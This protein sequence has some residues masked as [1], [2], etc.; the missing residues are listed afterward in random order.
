MEQLSHAVLHALSHSLE[1]ILLT[2]P[3]LFLVYLLMEFLESRMERWQHTIARLRGIGPAA[4]AAAGCIP[5]CGFSAAAASLYSRGFLT[6]GTLI[7]VFLSTSDEA[8]PVMLANLSGWQQIAALIGIK[9]VLAVAAGYLLDATVFRKETVTAVPAAHTHTH[10]KTDCCHTEKDPFRSPLGNLIWH[11]LLRTLQV[12]LFLIVTTFVIELAFHLIGEDRLHAL[13][14]NGSPLQPLLTALIGLI[15]GCAVSVLLTQLFIG[16]HIGFGA[17]VA[18][19]ATG[20]GVGYLVLFRE[21]GSLRKGLRI[22]GWTYCCA[23]AAGILLTVL[24]G[25]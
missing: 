15:P 24:T 13:L 17:A 6:G 23:A 12:T 4:G 21:C 11:A 3:I 1:H 14:L 10:T 22:V 19:L 2:I 9:L 5:Q 16:G 18:G 8:I 25:A 20:A 7:A